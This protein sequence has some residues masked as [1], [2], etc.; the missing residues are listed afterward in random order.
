MSTST[1]RTE[2]PGLSWRRRLLL[3][4]V[5]F[6]ALL[7]AY[8]ANGTI[9][10]EGDAVPTENLPLALLHA[11]R[12]SFGPEEF[13]EMFKWKTHP[14]FAPLD[15][16]FIMRWK[17]EIADRTARD[18]RDAGA[19]EFNGPRYYVT[20]SKLRHTYV[21]TFGPVPG[22]VLLPVMAPF[23]AV[24]HDL[25]RQLV[26]RATV[27]KLCA[28]ILVASSAVLILLIA[29]SYTAW[30][31]ALLVAVTYGLGT[32]AFAV[33]S[34]DLWQQTVTQFFLAL[35]AFFF[36]RKRAS[37]Q[38]AALAGFSFGA[39]TACRATGLFV[40]VAVLVHLAIYHRRRLLPYLVASAPVP[41]AV[42]VY[43][44]YFFGSP[45]VFAQELVGHV[46][47]LEKTGSP[48]LWQTP[49]W[50]GALGLLVSPSRGLLVFSPVLAASFWGAARTWRDPGFRAFRPLTVATL[51]MML[52]QCK[53]FDWWGGHA[54][55]YRPWLD[56]VPYLALFLVPVMDAMLRSPLRRTVFAA[57]LSWSVFVQGL[58]V[59]SY[60]RSWNMRRIF[61]TRSPG[62]R[63]PISFLTEPEARRFAAAHGEYLGPSYCDIDLWFCR[64]R[65]WSLSDNVILYQMNHFSETRGRRLP[66]TFGKV[67]P[68]L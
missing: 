41:L 64:Y 18:W 35:G 31:R 13:P 39:A 7:A 61:V 24:D 27:G 19:L 53:W 32:C 34:Q 57:L 40:F 49:L 50:E 67:E 45:F 62:A 43:N 16:F 58:G 12:L 28:S 8:H 2:H 22:F 60:D 42:A 25:P 29:L 37:W 47:A 5:L 23:Y 26:H 68:T 15:D 4:L 48:N 59:L 54:Y 44:Q 20:E 14:P 66:A 65:L 9:L 55:G 30:Q 38:A 46:I 51:A 56:V 21:S 36:L 17:D 52:L 33:S 6:C 3:C 1:G 63:R 10:N 11:G